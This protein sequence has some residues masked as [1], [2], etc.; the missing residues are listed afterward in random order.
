MHFSSRNNIVQERKSERIVCDLIHKSILLEYVAIGVHGI[1][2][3]DPYTYPYFHR[4]FLSITKYKQ[5]HNNPK[6]VNY[7]T[8]ISCVL[9]ETKFYSKRLA[10]FP[11]LI[12]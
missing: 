8:K 2:V 5:L 9:H 1:T 7:S 12:P 4:Y 6:G 3:T 11:N 10:Y